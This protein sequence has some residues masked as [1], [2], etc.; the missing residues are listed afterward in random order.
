MAVI[1]VKKT[2]AAVIDLAPPESGLQNQQV[3]RVPAFSV[4]II[5]ELSPVWLQCI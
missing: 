5:F 3:A 4:K 2:P 1:I